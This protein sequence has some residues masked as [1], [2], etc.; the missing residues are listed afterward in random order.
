[1]LILWKWLLL[2]ILCSFIIIVSY[3]DLLSSLVIKITSKDE[4]SLTW[5]VPWSFSLWTL[6]PMKDASGRERY[7]STEM[8][9]KNQFS[10]LWSLLNQITHQYGTFVG[11]V[12][13]FLLILINSGS[14]A[15]D[16][17]WHQKWFSCCVLYLFSLSLLEKTLVN[18]ILHI[19]RAN[20]EHFFTHLV[21][22]T[23]LLY[24]NCP[25]TLQYIFIPNCNW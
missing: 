3:I 22:W 17:Y 7:L 21:F 16:V 20:N 9:S 1:M 19:S 15:T 18:T 10:F 6:C 25:G 12:L 14:L 4:A 8:L 23:N 13:D 11:P 24:F 2:L 5:C